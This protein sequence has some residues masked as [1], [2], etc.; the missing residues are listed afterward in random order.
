MSFKALSQPI[1]FDEVNA[2]SQ[3]SGSVA[4]HKARRD[5]ELKQIIEGKDQRILL[6]IGPCSA[7]DE[8]AVLEYAT[9]LAKLQEKVKDKI[10]MVPRVYT[11]KPRT[12]GDGYKGLLH[13]PN[14]EGKVNLIQGIGAVRQLHNRVITETGLTTADEMLYPENLEF[15]DD[16]VSYIAIG[17]RSVEDQQHRFVASG[18]DQPT[19]MKNPTS[20]NLRVLFNSLHAAQHQ[21]EFIHNGI[22][23]ESSS[24]PLAH[25]V[26]RGGLNEYGENI[27]N[28]HYEDLMKVIGF[29]QKEKYKNP[30]IVIDTNHDNSGKQYKEQIRIVKETLENR[31]WNRDIKQLVR[32]FMIESYLVDGRQ[33]ADGKV[34]GQSI[35]DPCLGW[36]ASERLVDFIAEHA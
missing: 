31:N 16:L 23:V 11:N 7:H 15:I 14:P 18:I 22:E 21:Q 1:D 5:E 29:Y 4:E 24:N 6:L 28:Y 30:F 10:F 33:D 8:D 32:G 25:V 3:L 34:F 26:L 17:A 20:G 2:L 19:G 35:T 36:E 12:N 13:Q 9:R 27:P